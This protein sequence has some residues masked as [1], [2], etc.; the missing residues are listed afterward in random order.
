MDNGSTDI[1]ANVQISTLT[2]EVR[3]QLKAIPIENTDLFRFEPMSSLG[4]RLDIETI[5]NVDRAFIRNLDTGNSQRW[6]LFYYKDPVTFIDKS[7]SSSLFGF[8][9]NP[10]SG[11]T[12]LF[13]NEKLNQEAESQISNAYEQVVSAEHVSSN[14]EA[15]FSLS[16]DV[17][18]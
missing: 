9:P 12:K 13:L 1:N 11:N 18:S 15:E 2:D 5:N 10:T 4:K 6:K 16:L 17:A 14:S 8:Y 7:V 3:Q